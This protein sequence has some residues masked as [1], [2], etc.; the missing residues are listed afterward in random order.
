MLQAELE[1]LG[2]ASNEL[3]LL[4]DDQVWHS[5]LSCLLQPMISTA[6]WRGCRYDMLWE[7]AF[8]MPV[9]RRLRNSCKRVCIFTIKQTAKTFSP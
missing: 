5:V 4:D 8:T 7:K 3:M 1:D 2:D 6:D 9:Q